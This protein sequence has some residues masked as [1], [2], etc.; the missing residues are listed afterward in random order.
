MANQPKPNLIL[1]DLI[2]LWEKERSQPLPKI[3][4]IIVEILADHDITHDQLAIYKY[5]IESLTNVLNKRLQKLKQANHP[6]SNE[7]TGGRASPSTS[8]ISLPWEY[9]EANIASLLHKTGKYPLVFENI[10][11]L[12]KLRILQ[13]LAAL[14]QELGIQ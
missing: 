13:E 4:R 6:I 10:G 2:P 8:G 1:L 9:I 5:H 11:N 12:A 3:M 7:D 14:N